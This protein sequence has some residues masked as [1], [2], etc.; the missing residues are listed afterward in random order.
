MFA[1]YFTNIHTLLAKVI[2]NILVE[3]FAN[4]RALW[5]EYK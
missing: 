5:V 3:H 2:I 1:K 4:M